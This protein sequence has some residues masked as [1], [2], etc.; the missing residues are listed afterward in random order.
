M[1]TTCITRGPGS[2]F[3]VIAALTVLSACDLDVKNPGAI[4]DDDLNDPDLMGVVAA[5]VSAEFSDFVDNNA[6]VVARLTDEMVGSGSYSSTG[7]LRRGIIRRDDTGGEWNQMHESAWA[8]TEAIQ[9]FRDVLGEDATGHPFTARSHLFEGL[10]HRA[11]GEMFCEVAYD[12]GPAEPRSAAFQKSVAALNSAIDNSTTAAAEDFETAAWGGLAQAYV[13]LGDWDAAVAAAGRVPTSFVYEA[14]YHPAENNNVVFQETHDRPEMSAFQ[15][16]AGQF[17]PNDPRAP[18]TVC[19][20]M[21]PGGDVVETGNC[22]VAQGASGDKTPHWRQEKFDDLGSD[23]P[24]VKGTEMRLIE[25]EAA[26][27]DGD[28]AT[29]TSRINEVRTF[30]GTDPIEAPTSIGSLDNADPADAWS[31]LDRE[32]YLTLWLEGRRL[33]DLHRWEHPF[34]NGGALVDKYDVIDR[35]DSCYPISDD[36][37]DLNE[38][39][40]CT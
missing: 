22:R 5:G 15:T 13:G 1:N 33:W 10:A 28:L 31:I 29:F 25:A 40:Q 17:D 36:E 35:R 18:F 24:V 21:G 27:L 26:L 12:A 20:T 37:C 8:A 38:N 11:L 14:I 9:R 39:L 4:L 2:R 30:Y 7:L 23:I 16:L 34:L 3:L 32:R 6:F 19:G